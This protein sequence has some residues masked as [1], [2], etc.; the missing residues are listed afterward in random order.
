MYV[1]LVYDINVKRVGRALQICRR[2]LNWVQNSAFEGEL[3]ESKLRELK[4]RLKKLMDEKEDSVLI[5]RFHDQ[6]H[7]E[8]EVMGVEKNTTD[9]FL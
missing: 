4:L 5:Y 3:T 9:A 7:F 8:K 2:Y 6:K 1:I